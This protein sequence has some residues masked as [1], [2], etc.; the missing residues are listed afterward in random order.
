MTTSPAPQTPAFPAGAKLLFN[1]LPLGITGGIGVYTRRLLEALDRYFPTLDY[2]VV[3]PAELNRLTASLPP[4]R[5]IPLPGSVPFRAPLLREIAWQQR[6]GRYAAK[7]ATDRVFV[8][9]TDFYSTARPARSVVV[10]HDGM[11]ERMPAA[12]TRR[13]FVRLHYRRLC[14]RWAG[15]ANLVFT[16]SSWS[17]TDLATL[18]GL[19]EAKLRVVHPWVD[20]SFATRPTPTAIA[21]M[22]ACYGLPERYWLYLGGYRLYKNVDFLLRAYARLISDPRTP[23]LVLGGG[24][25]S[26]PRETLR[27]DPRP[28][29]AALGLSPQQ[30]LFPGAVEGRHLPAL[31]A[32]AELFVFPS[33]HE[34]FGY[35][36]LEAAAAGTPVLAARAASMPEVL[37][38]RVC[39][40]DPH[41][42][43]ELIDCLRTALDDP[44][45]YR[46]AFDPYYSEEPGITRWVKALQPIL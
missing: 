21:E 41:R 8:A 11:P 17:A 40:F 22:R 43:D 1:G 34:G 12:T 36:P 23:P 32:G 33:L 24:M 25:P 30:V 9:T 10:I 45:H 44:A 3:I 20:K 26:A 46:L 31:Y 37:T 38:T 7:H 28:V 5:V 4:E 14:N 27:L 6:I 39:G 18:G 13:T 35:T 2:R 29:A 16:V 19:P 42:L 15:R